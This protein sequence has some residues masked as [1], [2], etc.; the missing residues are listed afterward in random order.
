MLDFHV[1]NPL[2]T[3]C[4]AVSDLFEPAYRIKVSKIV[5]FTFHEV[6]KEG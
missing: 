4:E 3:W 6:D 2:Q 5:I 1:S